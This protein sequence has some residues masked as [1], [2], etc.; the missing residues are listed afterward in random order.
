MTPATD[1]YRT[2]GLIP[3]ATPAEIKRAYR[4][5]AK[6]YHPDS[7]GE[8][9]L[10]RFLAI[11]AA[12]E[13]L[14]A[15]Q[16]G[17][18]AVTGRAQPPRRGA[19]PGPPAPPAGRS[20]TADA[21][22]AR[23]TREGFRQR[24]ARS[25]AR[26]AG[27][28]PTDRTGAT[29]RTGPAG[30]SGGTTGGG[31]PRTGA[32]TRGSG[33]RGRPKATI[34]STSYD[35]TENE[36]FEPGWSGATWY[37]AASGTY[38][39]INPKEYADPRKHGP[40]YLARARR[41]RRSAAGSPD[42][43]GSSEG[44][45]EP[46]AAPSAAAGTNAA[47]AGP[48]A[49]AKPRAGPIVSEVP[50]RETAGRSS[51]GSHEFARLRPVSAPATSALPDPTAPADRPAPPPLTP[52]S[53]ARFPALDPARVVRSWRGRLA[54]MVLAWFPLGLAIFGIHGQVTGCAQ[55]MASCTDP[56]AWSVWIP[57]AI[58]LLVLL[59]SPRLAWIAASGSVLLICLAAPLAAVL[60]AGSGGRPPST[61]TT[62]LLYAAMAVGWLSGVGI[63]LSGRIPLPPW[64]TARV[65]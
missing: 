7:A 34:G 29:G 27:A 1:P 8:R 33:R 56:V 41:N 51:A 19:T 37:G 13:R 21:E 49:H 38:W 11:Q 14:T 58:V 59:A 60:T 5:L 10:P 6:A 30:A 15:G 35:G 18:P 65:R 47:P 39:T 25:G 63:A 40:E 45:F 36:P 17:G 12:Y 24:G 32:S 55:F 44:D 9:A 42:P 62:Q 16:P 4:R 43:A 57:Q 31:G 53:F 54:L 46:D 26:P 61:A 48:E 23:A 3:G 22:R 50:A 28:G 52:R 20:W 64:R 2:L